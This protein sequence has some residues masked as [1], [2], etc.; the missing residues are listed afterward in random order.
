MSK[1]ETSPVKEQLQCLTEVIKAKGG[2]G[3]SE[4]W[5]LPLCSHQ[6]SAVPGHRGDAQVRGGSQ[7]SPALGSQS[8][9]LQ[10]TK[11]W[12][13]DP[14]RVW[15]PPRVWE[16]KLSFDKRVLS[17]SNAVSLNNSHLWPVPLQ[18]AGRQAHLKCQQQQW[19]LQNKQSEC[20]SGQFPAQ[21]LLAM[22]C[23]SRRPR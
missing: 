20:S 4:A 7:H 13:G 19:H 23:L 8:C 9:S 3:I 15:G 1:P 21:S 11:S 6:C 2:L 5:P 22:G 10:S 14:G 12:A 17:G 18:H 16:N